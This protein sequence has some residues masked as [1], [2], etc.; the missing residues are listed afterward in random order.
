[1]TGRRATI[2]HLLA[3]AGRLGEPPVGRTLLVKYAY[4]VEVLRPAYELWQRAFQFVRYYHGPFAREVLSEVEFLVFHGFAKADHFEQSYGRIR[5]TYSVTEEGSALSAELTSVADGGLLYS[6]CE[7]LVW[8][9][10]C[11]GVRTAGAICNLVYQ[12][13]HFAQVLQRLQKEGTPHAI[14]VTLAD[15]RRIDHP[16]NRALSIAAAMR[17]QW[18][19]GTTS[20]RKLVAVYLRYL[21]ARMRAK[22]RRGDMRA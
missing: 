10:Q 14:E 18:G 7:D 9:L 11:L 1:M 22:Q 17:R 6:L 3:A 15:P 20:S 8:N 19:E 16:S 2:M 13:P 4:L 5:A 12:E 21:A